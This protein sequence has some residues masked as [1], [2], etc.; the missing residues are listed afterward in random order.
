MLGEVF[1]VQSNELCDEPRH[2]QVKH[3]DRAPPGDARDLGRSDVPVF[4]VFLAEQRP[5]VGFA[6]A[7]AGHG[8]VGRGRGA[9]GG[10]MVRKRSE[11]VWREDDC[12]E[13][14]TRPQKRTST[15]R[16]SPYVSRLPVPRYRR[17][18]D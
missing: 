9:S 4:R 16:V 2:V 13:T 18:R 15:S 14:T 17:F 10:G 7:V 5:G 6:R 1:H 12:E 3:P 11:P 8:G